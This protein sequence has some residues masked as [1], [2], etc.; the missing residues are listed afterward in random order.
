MNKTNNPKSNG[1]VSEFDINALKLIRNNVK[2]FMKSSAAK[3]D[4]KDLQ[5]LDIAPQIHAGAKAHFNLANISTLD[6]DPS[7]NATIIADL[8][9]NNDKLIKNESFDIVVCTEV[10]E[11]TLNPFKAMAEIHRILKPNGIA[12]ISTPFNFRI[13]GPLP[14]CWRFS[15]HGLRSLFADFEE[16]NISALETND[17]FLMPIHYTSI[18]KKNKDF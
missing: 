18:I 5:L 16:I 8:C 12:L 4:K 10:L 11:H 17:R 9:C 3:Y 1:Q 7:S 2:N 14:D 13:H 15:I 6:I